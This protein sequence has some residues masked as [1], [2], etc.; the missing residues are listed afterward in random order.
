MF[1]VF[2]VMVMCLVE[3]CNQGGGGGGG[4]V[5][6]VVVCGLC[7]VLHGLFTVPLGAT[8]RLFL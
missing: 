5:C 1:V 3:H 7:T 4:W 8:G 2:F 6:I